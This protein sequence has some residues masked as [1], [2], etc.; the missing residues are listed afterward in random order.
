M[1]ILSMSFLL[2]FYGLY[3]ELSAFRLNRKIRRLI[4]AKKPLTSPR[5]CLAAQRCGYLR[6]SFAN[7]SERLN[8][9]I[10]KQYEM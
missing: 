2:F 9:E 4:I 1:K 8:L 6:A 7:L 5:L 10:A 3:I